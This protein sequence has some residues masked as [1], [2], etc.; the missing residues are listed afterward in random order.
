VSAKPGNFKL[1]MDAMAEGSEEAAWQLTELYTPHI[2]RAV[3]SSLPKRI[4]T[5]VDSQDFVQSVWASILLNRGRLEQFQNP[6]QFVGYLAAMAKNKVI[7]KY[8]HFRTQKKDVCAEV[9]ISAI[10]RTSPGTSTPKAD[11]EDLLPLPASDPTP[12]QVAV[13]REGWQQLIDQSSKRDRQIVSMRI[14]GQTY[15][16]IANSLKVNEKTI[17]RAL[18]RMLV[19][20][21]Q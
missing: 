5:K 11:D 16:A 14:S 1:L 10:D 6:K 21:Q 12:S 18:N 13:A 2:M 9:R 20:Y 15:T 4:R 8:R 19:E 7:D 17:Q 3:R